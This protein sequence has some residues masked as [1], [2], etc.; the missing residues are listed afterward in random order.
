[1]KIHQLHCWFS[2]VWSITSM[3]DYQIGSRFSSRT[4]RWSAS[5][6]RLWGLFSNM[7]WNH[8]KMGQRRGSVAAFASHGFAATKIEW[9][10]S[11]RGV[12]YVCVWDSYQ[13]LSVYK[14]NKDV[15]GVRFICYCHDQRRLGK[16]CC[17]IEHFAKVLDRWIATK[18]NFIECNL[19][20]NIFKGLCRCHCTHWSLMLSRAKV[21]YFGHPTRRKTLRTPQMDRWTWKVAS[22]LCFCWKVSFLAFLV[23]CNLSFDVSFI[24]LACRIICEGMMAKVTIVYTHRHIVESITLKCI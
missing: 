11:M 5:T 15:S 21:S 8:R 6:L 3:K 1:M 14:K 23:W 13:I 17:S 16:C 10:Q 4:L 2:F 7:S 24:P 22:A 18:Y 19:Y 12:G 9:S 20:A